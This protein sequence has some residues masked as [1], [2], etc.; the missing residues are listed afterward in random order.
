MFQLWRLLPNAL[1]PAEAWISAA[2]SWA[3]AGSQFLCGTDR[4]A[5]VAGYGWML[6]LTVVGFVAGLNVLAAKASPWAK[7]AAF[8]PTLACAG[9]LFIL[10]IGAIQ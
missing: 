1:G 10:C 6:G 2:L 4:G 9:R 7:G 8:I 3:G 5:S